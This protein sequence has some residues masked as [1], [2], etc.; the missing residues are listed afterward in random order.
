MPGRHQVSPVQRPALRWLAA[1]AGASVVTAVLLA[2]FPGS[3]GASGDPV[4]ATFSVT[5]VST[6][7]CAVSTGGTDV[8]VKPGQEL[9]V[10][11]SAVG[12]TVLG[13]PVDIS[14]VASFAGA[15]TIDPG[16][17]SQQKLTISPTFQKVAALTSG[18][19]A[20]KWSVTGVTL[21]GGA[22]LPLN[23]SSSALAAGAELTYTGTIHVTDAAAQC[24][25]SAQ[26]PGVGASV[27]ITG[28][29]TIAVSIP[30]VKLPT[31]PV[32]VP[33]GGLPNVP[34]VGQSS[35]SHA[36]PPA[37]AP[38]GGDGN[39]LPVPARV[40]PKGDGNAVFGNAGGAYVPAVIPGSGDLGGGPSGLLPV[41]ANGSPKAA[42]PSKAA[43]QQV[44]TGKHKTIDL[45]AN[46]ATS[47]GQF[48]VILAIV[49]IIALSIVAATYA[50]L[51]LLR[52]QPVTPTAE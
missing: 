15:L 47:T 12:M 43:V 29:P 31:L 19:H 4:K 3:A 45:A 51:Y 44:S 11:S 48:S 42:A 40:V 37:S 28:L 14:N 49:A 5:G 17:T 33:T 2:F 24:G 8:Y 30:G 20:F 18:N 35:G 26:V 38:A 34:G 1:A 52:R 21:L 46:K 16:K 23:L 9:D 13:L 6:S 41:V 22:T 7:N 50:R 25:I 10:K 39:L 36:K 27:S 32:N